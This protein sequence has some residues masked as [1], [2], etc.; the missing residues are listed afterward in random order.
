MCMWIIYKTA[1]QIIENADSNWGEEAEEEEKGG[2]EILH[3]WQSPR[4][5]LQWGWRCHFKDH[6]LQNESV[7]PPPLG[8]DM[9]DG[10]FPLDLLRTS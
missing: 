2:A 10:L 5:L 9:R 3:F 6:T 1:F 8:T 4:S 7:T